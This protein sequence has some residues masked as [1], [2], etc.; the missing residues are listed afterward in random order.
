MTNAATLDTL[1]IYS[2]SMQKPIRC[3]VILPETYSLHRETYP[4]LYLLHGWSGDYTGWLN[5]APQLRQHADTY[6]III[7]CP[8]GGFDSWY[9]DSPVDSTVRYETHIVQEVLPTV[10][11]YFHTRRDRGGRAIAG[12]SMGGHGAFYLAAR[13]P[14]LFGAVGSMSGGLDLR[15]WKHNDWDLKK[16][17][18]DPSGHWQNWEAVSAVNLVPQLKAADL[19]VIMSCGTEDFFLPTNRAMHQALLAAGVAHQYLESPGE[20]NHEFWGKAVDAQVAFFAQF[21]SK[22]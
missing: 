16:I 20:H 10:D 19:Q 14:E 11:Y 5:D 2:Q 4:V 15:A 18:G 13:H 17:L 3:L 21:F 1:E 8:D 22:K 12:L 6:N 7:V 9:V